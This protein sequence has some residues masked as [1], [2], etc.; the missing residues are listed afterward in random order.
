MCSAQRKAILAITQ[1]SLGQRCRPPAVRKVSKNNG[2]FALSTRCCAFLV[3]V[4][5][6]LLRCYVSKTVGN[7]D[8][9]KI[10]CS[11]S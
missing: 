7:K 3:Q 6:I 4:D 2:K 1:Q 11:D 9:F 5:K 8:I 10:A